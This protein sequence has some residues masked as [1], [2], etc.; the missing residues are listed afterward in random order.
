MCCVPCYGGL[1]EAPAR[2]GPKEAP[3][4]AGIPGHV[5]YPGNVHHQDDG[6]QVPLALWSHSQLLCSELRLP[7]MRLSYAAVSASRALSGMREY[8]FP[9]AGGARAGLWKAP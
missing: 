5:P 6:K 9:E 8:G 7:Q 4:W 3:A 2:W 1:S